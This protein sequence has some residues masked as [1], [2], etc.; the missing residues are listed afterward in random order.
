MYTLCEKEE[1]TREGMWVICT[2]CTSE[3][4]LQR[5]ADPKRAMQMH[6][7]PYPSGVGKYTGPPL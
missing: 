5:R 4:S 1:W 2:H 6:Y 7:A 3:G